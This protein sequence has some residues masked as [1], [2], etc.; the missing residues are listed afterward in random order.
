MQA[1]RRI[2]LVYQLTITIHRKDTTAIN[3][4]TEIC[5]SMSTSD[6][7]WAAFVAR[8]RG[9]HPADSVFISPK[10]VFGVGTIAVATFGKELYCTTL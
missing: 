6:Q 3:T 2:D 5:E 10:L 8:Y 1:T 4:T 7:S 9:R